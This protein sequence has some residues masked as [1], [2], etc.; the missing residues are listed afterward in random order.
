MPDAP[1]LS[2]S[3]SLLPPLDDD[4]AG[5]A[6]L[7]AKVE[8]ERPFRCRS[9]KERCLRRRVAVR[10]RAR[11]VH[12]FADYARVLDDDAAEYDRL[13]DALTINVTKFFRNCEAW[14][15]LAER[16]IPALLA[17]AR[18]PVRVWSAG[19]A[20][21]EEAYSLAASFHAAGAARGGPAAGGLEVVGTDV[22][23]RSLRSAAEG[24]YG[25]AAF[26]ET[27]PEVRARYF[28]AG[29]PARVVPE[30]R[31]VTRFAHHDLLRDPA[32]AGP[33]DLIACR[34]VVIYFDRESQEALFD[35]FHSVLAPGGVLFLGKVETLLGR[36][37]GAY[38]PV[39]HRQRIYRR[40]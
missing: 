23:R 40:A 25:D 26:G 20:S 19:C 36:T 22:D 6:A 29:S 31:A 2:S 8:D 33:W 7:I 3:A 5:F 11:G 1:A 13:L 37:R 15:T 24:V 28:T 9:Y 21:G 30:L 4:P 35:R 27:P 14:S 32:P 16:A 39:D 38:V 10:M 18:R 17:D 12:T 34:N